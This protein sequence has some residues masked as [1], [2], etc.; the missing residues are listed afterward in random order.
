LDY[1]Q[2]PCEA[3]EACKQ[4]LI[5][6]PADEFSPVFLLSAHRAQGCPDSAVP[7]LKAALASAPANRSAE[8]CVGRALLLAH[9]Y[10]E[11]ED[12]LKELAG[13]APLHG[14]DDAGFA[15]W[16]FLYEYYSDVLCDLTLA[17]EAAEGASA[18]RH[19]ENVK[20]ATWLLARGTISL[21]TFT[22][23]YGVVGGILPFL[24]L[25]PSYFHGQMSL[26]TMF[27]IEGLL[28]GVQQSLG[29]FIGSYVDIAEWR[30][31]AGRLLALEAIVDDVSLRTF[32]GEEENSNNDSSIIALGSHLG[33]K[34][35]TIVDSSG[36]P[37]LEDA[38][39]EWYPGDLIALGG[40]PGSGK[41]ALLRM[42]AGAWPPPTAGCLVPSVRG[43][44][45]LL[46]PSTGFLLPQRATL[47]MCLAYPD[48]DAPEDTELVQALL[49]CGLEELAGQLSVEAD[50]SAALSLSDRQRLV[51]VRL[52]AR[53]P[54]G[55]RWLLLD[56]IDTALDV[57]Q[58][59]E[60]HD[61]LVSTLPDSVGLVT[62]SCHREMLHRPGWRRFIMDHAAKQ[63]TEESAFAS[64]GEAPG[65]FLQIPDD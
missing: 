3:A 20:A 25:V 39:F 21:T 11:A 12:A 15:A 30:A 41:S 27:Q 5:L 60:L 47:R 23:A 13:R 33:A 24:V 44:G 37:L 42:L 36:T 18:T 63:L 7:Q 61:L 28:G 10:E 53:W 34:S 4:A 22:S 35:L 32:Q 29:I 19:F 51:F 48:A 58:T 43:V 52:V 40:D 6:H 64:T 1:L 14:H 31:S 17:G 65:G 49:R 38:C 45:V 56:E 8:L 9:R 57:T 46:V 16:I 50:W 62:T 2:R 59:F 54:A 26:G 55:I